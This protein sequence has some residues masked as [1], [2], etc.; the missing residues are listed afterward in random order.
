MRIGI[1]ARFWNESGVG[2][3]IRNLVAELAKIDEKNQYVLFVSK[4]DFETIPDFGKNWKK[5][6][7]DIKWHSVEEQIQYPLLLYRIKLDLMHFPYFSVPISY[8]KP[9]V[10]TIHDLILHHFATGKATTRSPIAYYLKLL[11]YQIVMR[12]AAQKAQKIIAVTHATKDEIID[13]LGVEPEKIKVIYEGV[14]AQ[15][16]GN[17]NKLEN[18]KYPYF[19]HV[20]NLYPH[21]NMEKLLE[22]FKKVTQE[23]ALEVKLVIVGKKD[24][25]Y[26]RFKQRVVDEKLENNVYF[27]G[28]VSDEQLGDL[29]RHALGLVMPSLMEGFSLPT[30]EAMANE[31]L[32]IASDIPVHREICGDAAVYFLPEDVKN[33]SDKLLEV[34]LSPNEEYKEKKKIGLQR[35]QHFSWKAMAKETLKLYESGISIR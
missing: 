9:F 4:K 22:A 2:R 21:K 32:V 20:G 27:M 17:K 35:V 10:V 23:K 3:Y 13:H 25:F 34:Y 24:F 16:V 11:S 15:I 7:A 31:C 8:N 33:I 1:D 14:D 5:K 30:V 19:L 6:V 12:R 26:R 29:Y 28:E 18:L